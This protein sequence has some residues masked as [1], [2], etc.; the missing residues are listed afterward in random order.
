MRRLAVVAVLTVLTAGCGG[1]ST[2]PC[3]PCPTNFT[4]NAASG[5]CVPATSTAAGGSSG[6]ATTAGAASTSGGSTSAGS[7]TST[8]GTGSTGG[9]T[10]GWT[11][12]VTAQG[13]AVSRL[14]FAAVGDSRPPTL[15]DTTGYPTAIITK[16]FQDITQANPEF[17]VATGDYMFASPGGAQGAAQLQLYMNARAAYPGVLFASMG[18]HECTGYTASNCLTAGSS[19]NY[20]SYLQQLV[21]PLG[22]SLPYYRVDLRDSAG[23]WTAKFLILA[24]NSWDQAQGTWLQQQMAQPT[25]YTFIVRHEPESATTAPGVSPSDAIIAQYPYTLKIVGHTHSFSRAG[26]RQVIVGNGGAPISGGS[27]YGYAIIEQLPTGEIK[28][29]NMDYNS[30]A[31][32]SSFVVPK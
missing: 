20:Q 9:S 28:V 26:T 2:A 29:S 30:N 23:A 11:G 24:M 10:G 22:Q 4:C 5:T 6:G 27:S 14:Y 19:N 16:I 17:V 31:A 3:P 8:G 12:S 25:T 21:S 1:S 15:D 32:V 13:G 18:N 7:T